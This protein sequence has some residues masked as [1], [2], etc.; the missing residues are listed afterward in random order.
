MA[1][2]KDT[3]QTEETPAPK[4]VDIMIERHSPD[5]KDVYGAVNGEDYLIKRG[6]H[7]QVPYYIAEVLHNSQRMRAE[8]MERKMALA[9]RRR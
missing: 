3:V 7:V 5:E 4:M 9:E 6:V 1:K 8:A 2:E